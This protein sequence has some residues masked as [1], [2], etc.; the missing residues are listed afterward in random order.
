[1]IEK[2]L[3]VVPSIVSMV[4]IPNAIETITILTSNQAIDTDTINEMNLHLLRTMNNTYLTHIGDDVTI[5]L[6]N[7]DSLNITFGQQYR[8]QRR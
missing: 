6:W 1:M 3:V 5:V 7:K 4:G 8:R 2:I